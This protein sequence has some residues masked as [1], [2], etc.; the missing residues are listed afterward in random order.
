MMANRSTFSHWEANELDAL[1]EGVNTFRKDLNKILASKVKLC[2]TVVDLKDKCRLQSNSRTV[3]AGNLP[4]RKFT[5]LREQHE[6]FPSNLVY[7]V[8][9]PKSAAIKAATKYKFYSKENDSP[10]IRLVE[11]QGSG[12]DSQKTKWRSTVYAF[13]VDNEGCIMREKRQ[14]SLAF[15]VFC[16]RHMALKLKEAIQRAQAYG[17]SILIAELLVSSELPKHLRKEHP[18]DFPIEFLDEPSKEETLAEIPQKRP[19]KRLEQL[20]K[21]Q[22]SH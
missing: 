1:K 10:N 19:R 6:R 5:I 3:K 2:R 13:Q 16:E 4:T 20:Q 8:C 15:Q 17:G 14:L 22:S 12:R 9:C 7:V 18:K 11:L 21:V